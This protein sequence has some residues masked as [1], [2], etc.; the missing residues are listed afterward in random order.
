MKRIFVVIS[1]LVLGVATAQTA[2]KWIFSYQPVKGRY[3]IYGGGLADPLPPTSKDK[4]IAFWIEG[5]AAKQLFDA[6]GPDLRNTCGADGDY[7]VR[8]RA[9][10]SCTYYP[11]DGYHCD[12]GFDLL[13]GRSV[14]GSV[15]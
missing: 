11:G 1:F 4:R 8:Q 15:C 12:F 7:R 5:K 9:E 10:V 3:L 14:G 6:M 13:T 2:H